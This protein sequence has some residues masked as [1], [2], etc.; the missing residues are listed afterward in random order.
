RLLQQYDVK[1]GQTLLF[2]AFEPSLGKVV[3]TTVRIKEREEAELFAGKQKKRLLRVESQIDKIGNIQLPTMVSWLG[4]DLM[5]RRSEA[6]VPPFGKMTLYRTTKAI[7]TS[8]ADADKLI[9][10]SADQYVKLKR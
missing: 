10:I 1:P 5:P 2:E 8:A 9:D 7:A 3:K 4:D 6:E